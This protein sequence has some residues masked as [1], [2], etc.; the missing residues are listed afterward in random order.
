MLMVMMELEGRTDEALFL[1]V[2]MRLYKSAWAIVLFSGSSASSELDETEAFGR[3]NLQG[4]ANEQMTT[5]T[6]MQVNIRPTQ[7]T[8]R[9]SAP[10][11]GALAS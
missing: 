5:T 8:Q 10:A 3:S 2:V 1:K 9:A 11:S 6:A 4:S 7:A